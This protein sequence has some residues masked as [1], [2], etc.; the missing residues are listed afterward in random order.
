[1]ILRGL[2]FIGRLI[3]ESQEPFMKRK[4]ALTAMLALVP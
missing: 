2:V 3:F 4:I 1:M